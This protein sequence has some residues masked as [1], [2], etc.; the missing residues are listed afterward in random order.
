MVSGLRRVPFPP[1][2]R[3]AFMTIYDLTCGTMNT[4]TNEP[5]ELAHAGAY[6]SRA[7][8]R[9]CAADRVRRAADCGHSEGARRGRDLC[10]R[11]GY[12][13]ARRL[14]R[15]APETSDMARANARSR[16]RQ[17]AHLGRIHLAG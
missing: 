8:A 12:G 16:R 6:F 1:A 2:R 7:T 11:I 9:G 17:A 3:I 4:S 10:D 14:S 5:A 13:L 15:T